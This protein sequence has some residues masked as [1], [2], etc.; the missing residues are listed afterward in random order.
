MTAKRERPIRKM[1]SFSE[2]EWA[3]IERRMQLADAR[4]FEQFGRSALLESKIVV[5]RESLFDHHE[6]GAELN[7]IGTNINQIARNVNTE[8][9]TTLEEMKATRAMVREIQTA[10]ETAREQADRD[11]S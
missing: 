4:N 8:Q 11:E 6:L 5:R 10:I 3:S 1:L 2:Q 9:T 7:R